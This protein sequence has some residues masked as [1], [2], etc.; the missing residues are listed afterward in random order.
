MLAVLSIYYTKKKFLYLSHLERI[1]KVSFYIMYVS[2][3]KVKETD[4]ATIIMA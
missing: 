3:Q 4:L 1:Q 2:L